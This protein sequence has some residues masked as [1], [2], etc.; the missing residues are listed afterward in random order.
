MDQVHVGYGWMSHYFEVPG[1]G[2]YVQFLS[3][4]PCCCCLATDRMNGL[5]IIIVYDMIGKQIWIAILF[6]RKASNFFAAA[7]RT[8]L[9][10]EPNRHVNFPQIMLH[11]GKLSI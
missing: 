9:M 7:S 2:I 8:T 10:M 11:I 4:L 1:P 3:A 6:V 5:A